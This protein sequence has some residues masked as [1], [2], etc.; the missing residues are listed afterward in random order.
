MCARACAFVFVRVSVQ[1]VVFGLYPWTPLWSLVSPPR[2][3]HAT[4]LNPTARYPV[5]CILTVQTKRLVAVGGRS[6]AYE[7]DLNAKQASGSRDALAK[8]IYEKLFSWIVGAVNL[9]LASHK[10]SSGV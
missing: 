5:S 2:T 1:G 10:S 9:S 3:V 7:K 4:P 8:S 6:S